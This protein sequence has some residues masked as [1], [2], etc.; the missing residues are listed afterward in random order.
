[1]NLTGLDWQVCS[2]SAAA[3]PTA[4]DAQRDAE[5][6]DWL[7]AQVPGTAATAWHA[8]GLFDINHPAPLHDRDIWYRCTLDALGPHQ[9]VLSGVATVAEVYLD[10]ACVARSS[11]MFVPIEVPVTLTGRHTLHLACRSL[12][13]HLA[14]LKLPRARWR[15][16]MVPQQALRGVRTTLLGHMPS[17]CPE[18]PVVGPWRAV[19]LLPAHALHAVVMKATAAGATGGELSVAFR[20]ERD[21]SGWTVSCAGQHGP[22]QRTADGHWQAALQFDEVARWWPRGYGPPT[23]HDVTLTNGTE[24]LPLGRAGFRSVAVDRGPDGK[25]FTLVVNG[26]PVF[27]R[28]A[29]YTPP[30]VLHPGALAGAAERLQQLADMGANMLRIAGPFCYEDPAFFGLCAD[31]GLMIWQDLMLANFDYPLRDSAFLSQVDAE[32]VALLTPLAANPSL[33]VL[34]GGSEVMQQAAMLGVPVKAEAFAF[35]NEHLR[36]LCNG[37]CP[38]VAVVPNSPCGGDVPFSVRTGVSHYYGVGAY[39]RPLADARLA[40]PRFI[41]ECLAFAHV[42]DPCTTEAMG[43]PAVH[44]PA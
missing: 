11:S 14:G 9:L 25:G 18:V 39:E 36:V 3:W 6:T 21:V 16:G 17:W 23:Q 27:A 12:T 22:V 38:G 2:T 5:T 43:V 33:V 44:H 31:L 30:N 28:G 26:Q 29:V 41:S 24:V 10:G 15:V 1:M 20:F 40:A 37:V 34:C 42:P 7:R 19:H 4:Q 8:A 35:F 13:A 32:V